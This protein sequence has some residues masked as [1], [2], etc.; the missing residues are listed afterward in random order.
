MPAI[1]RH[2]RPGEPRY[3]EDFK[4]GDLTETSGFAVTRDMILSFAEQYDPQ[5]MHLMRRLHVTRSSG[6]WSAV[7]GRRW[8]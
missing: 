7:A 2:P 8:L 6:S 5:P 3:L 4:V 1:T